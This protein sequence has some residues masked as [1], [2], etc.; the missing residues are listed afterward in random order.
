LDSFIIKRFFYRFIKL[1]YREVIMRRRIWMVALFGMAAMLT[2]SC[3]GIEG[4]LAMPEEMTPTPEAAPAPAKPVPAEAPPPPPSR[5]PQPPAPQSELDRLPKI[6]PVDQYHGQ[7]A[8][9]IYTSSAALPEIVAFYKR[10]MAKQGWK[11]TE[12]QTDNL[13]YA[14]LNFT[15]NKELLII[16]LGSDTGASPPR[17]MVSLTAHGSMKVKDLPRYP[18]TKTLAEFDH[19]AIYLT[20]DGIEK[21]QQRTAQMLAKAGWQER[22]APAGSGD[23]VTFELEKGQ[24][25]LNVYISVAPAQGNKTAIQYSLRKMD[26]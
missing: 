12:T 5:P 22:G 20:A 18:G 25:L 7:D 9:A 4:L 23:N 1:D 21:V 24:M 15:K 14:N 8:G 10:E 13:N 3:T 26:R 16:S 17:V 2:A 19:T 6:A 11:S